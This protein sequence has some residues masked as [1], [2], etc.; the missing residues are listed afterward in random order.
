MGGRLCGRKKEN[1]LS[2][3][4]S[5]LSKHLEGLGGFFLSFICSDNRLIAL[6]TI[7]EG[8]TFI[9]LLATE[10]GMTFSLVKISHFRPAKFSNKYILEV[11]SKFF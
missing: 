7:E 5:L 10:E 8:K 11:P 9:A 4:S 6:L 3:V 1:C 2:Q